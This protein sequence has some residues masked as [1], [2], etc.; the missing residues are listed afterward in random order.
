MDDL[1]YLHPAGETVSGSDRDD[2][3]AQLREAGWEGDG[4]LGVLW[5]PPFVGVGVEDT[6][7][8]KIFHVK[9]SNNGTSWLASPYALDFERLRRQNEPVPKPGTPVN[10]L[11]SEV[12]HL[13]EAV[14]AVLGPLRQNLDGLQALP[15]VD[16]ARD[17]EQQLLIRA[18]EMLVAALNDF[19]DDCS[20][21]VLIHVVDRGN[22]YKFTVPKINAKLD[23]SSYVP[24]ELD[25][26]DAWFTLKGLT[27]DVWRSYRFLP[28]KEKQ[29]FLFKS[30]GFV[31]DEE[32]LRLI[33]KHVAIRNSL[34]HHGGG[35]GGPMLQ[36]LGVKTL[37]IRTAEGELSLKG[38]DKI[39]LT[40]EEVELLAEALIDL[41]S[42]LSDH[43]DVRVP[44][45]DWLVKG[46]ES[47]E[48]A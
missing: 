43:V 10:I 31:G 5:L 48:L 32:R 36:M 16:C 3:E 20:L 35:V 19:L 11:F 24:E 30:L 44:E 21:K 12:E 4:E 1:S 8:T 2:V 27:S 34:Q 14:D 22:P 18:Q 23:A 9:Q 42:E 25:D 33:R 29:Q 7:G 40:F 13:G 38:G 15:D 46:T 6:Y 26:K 41:A 17:I 47:D 45:R 28:F 37:T 39:V